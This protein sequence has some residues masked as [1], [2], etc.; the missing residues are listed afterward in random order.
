MTDQPWDEHPGW[1]PFP[2]HLIDLAIAEMRTDGEASLD[3][4]DRQ[5][6][7]L[8]RL[9][10]TGVVA[11]AV[12]LTAG[13]VALC[14]AL[15]GGQGVSGVRRFS[16]MAVVLVVFGL[17]WLWRGRSI[18]ARIPAQRID[19]ANRRARFEQGYR[20]IRRREGGS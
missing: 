10:W 20:E 13:G 14:L 7:R 6:D 12:L 9:G 16:G 15:F 5:I 18:L 17:I 1:R 11:G 3:H 2:S 19:V 4:L 8:A